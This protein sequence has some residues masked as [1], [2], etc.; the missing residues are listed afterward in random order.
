MRTQSSASPDDIDLAALGAAV[1]RVLPKLFFA[2]LVVGAVSFAILSMLTPK[3]ASQAQIEI[4]SKGLGNP[5]EPRRDSGT[6]EL[7]SVRMDKEAIATHV[8]ALQS[9]D[10][11]LKL[12]AELKLA[13]KPEFNSTLAH[14]GPVG[15]ALHLIGLA[16]PR[17][18]ETEDELVLAAY[19][20]ALRVYQVKDT[21]GIMIDFRSSDPKLAA[22]VANKLAE[23]YRD[24][25]SLRAV[26]ESRDART[27]LEPQIKKLAQ[28]V[29][30]A[31]AE[32][33]RFRGQSNI[34][35]GGRE[36]TGLNGSSSPS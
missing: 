27:K 26:L 21:R 10:L 23:L 34:F 5:F 8:R 2:T 33:T 1:K 31:E 19:Y 16:G 22:E 32:V 9:S 12:A 11:G 35:D 29:A 4:I 6:P 36:K 30:E 15:R 7:V 24:D 18:G 20:D 3:Y 17:P 14:R 25:L 13:S 28:E